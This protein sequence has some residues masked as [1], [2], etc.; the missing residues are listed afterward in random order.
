MLALQGPRHKVVVEE[1][2]ITRSRLAGVRTA[3]PVDVG[4][5][6]EYVGRGTVQVETMI[7]GT[8]EVTEYPLNQVKVWFPRIM[9]MKTHL[10][11]GISDIWAGER[12]VLEHTGQTVVLCGV[13]DRRAAGH[14]E[15]VSMGMLR[16][17][18]QRMPVRS[19]TLRMYC[20]WERI[21]Q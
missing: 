16:G 14:W 17:R 8:I 21:I 2:V 7:N 11:D 18:Q 10:L 5:G 20:R 15:L 3:D 4:V 9:H 6:S 19:R 1:D 12:H 13:V